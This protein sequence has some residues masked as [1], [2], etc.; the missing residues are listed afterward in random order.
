MVISAKSQAQQSIKVCRNQNLNNNDAIIMLPESWIEIKNI[1]TFCIVCICSRI[2]L[3]FNYTR[4]LLFRYKRL[5]IIV[6]LKTFK[7]R[8]LVTS[9]QVDVMTSRLVH[10]ATTLDVIHRDFQ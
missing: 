6:S 9:R 8:R 2:S 3:I 4:R 7:R 10:V 1:T 5:T